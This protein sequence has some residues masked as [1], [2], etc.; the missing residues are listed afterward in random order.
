MPLLSAA[1][2]VTVS[3][4]VPPVMV[5]A[6]ETV[7]LLVPLAKVERVA[8]GAEV[9]RAVGDGGAE[10]DGVVPVPPRRVSTLLRVPVLRR[11]PG[12]AC[13]RRCR[14]RPTCRWRGRCRG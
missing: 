1:P 9:D 11:S 8:A 3:A 12:R 2:S 14:D 13:R 5:S 6:L 4:P 10:G 7:E